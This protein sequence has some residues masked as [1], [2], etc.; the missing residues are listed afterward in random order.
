M[1]T[2][3]KKAWCE[4]GAKSEMLFTEKMLDSGFGVMCNPAKKGDPYTHDFYL[5][6][7][8]D[9]KTIRTRFRTAD[10]YGIP[11]FSAITLNVKDVDRYIKLY[12]HIVIIFD[13]DYG[14]YKRLCYAPLRQI[15]DLIKSG[16]AV[17]H[18]YQNRVDDKLGNARDSYV[19]DAEWFTRM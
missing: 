17:R 5:T 10:R 12:P 15:Y 6:L 2:E 19:L 8:S 4:A 11:P 16:K 13:V 7:P 14:D 3:D 1:N 18:I 9:L